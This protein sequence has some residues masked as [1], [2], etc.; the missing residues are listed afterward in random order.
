MS[1]FEKLKQSLSSTRAAWLVTGAA[2]FIG[3]NL[4]E[5]T[6]SPRGARKIWIKSAPLWGR[7]CGKISDG[8][9]ET[10]ATLRFVG[11]PPKA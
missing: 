9:K 5:W 7:P 3:S 4:L 6:T 2:G 8:S 11:E 10:F 1:E